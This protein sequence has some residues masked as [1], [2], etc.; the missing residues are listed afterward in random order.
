MPERFAVNWTGVIA[1]LYL[2][3]VALLATRLALGYLAVRR[4]VGR[5]KEFLDSRMVEPA[6]RRAMRCGCR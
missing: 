2:F 4:L 5:A 1:A 6:W 3:G